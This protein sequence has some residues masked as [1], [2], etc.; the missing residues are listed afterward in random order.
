MANYFEGLKNRNEVKQRFGELAIKY[1]PDRIG[2][3]PENEA[4]MADIIKQYKAAI[5]WF[6]THEEVF[7]SGKTYSGNAEKSFADLDNGYFAIV[8]ILLKLKINI[9][10]CGAWLWLHG[11]DKDD[12]ETRK[13]IK[14]AGC[15]WAK[16]KKLW[17]W[18]PAD[19]RSA[20]RT[21]KTWDFQQIR[22]VFG[23]KAVFETHYQKPQTLLV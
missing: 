22:E 1:H 3:T 12:I 15:R 4:R 20:K 5:E 7:A 10:C 17:Y 21:G 2:S 16:D 11:V 18:R 23:S 13:T 19:Y 9:E 6:K 14:N 8:N